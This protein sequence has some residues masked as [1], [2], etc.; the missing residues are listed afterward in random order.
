MLHDNASRPAR[1]AA[2][3]RS[4]V[5]SLAYPAAMACAGLASAAASAQSPPPPSAS[6]VTPRSL[7]PTPPPA[8]APVLE[9]PAGAAAKAPPGSE[10]LHVAVRRVVIDGGFDE[11]AKE[12]ARLAAPVEG[13]SVTVA[14]LYKVAGQIEAMYAKA[15]YFLVRAAVPQ[16]ALVDGGDFRLTVIDGFFDVID[17]TAVPRKLKRPVRAIM[18]GLRGRHKLKLASLQQRLDAAQAVPGSRL[19]ST[20]AQGETAGAARLILDGGFKPFAATLGGDNKLG[21]AF[22]D[23]GLNL[24]LTANS[25]TGH[26]EQVYA[27]L[28]GTPRR[29]LFGRQANRRILG[30]GVIA[31]LNGQGLT[32]NP[33]FTFS[34]TRPLTAVPLLASHDKLYRGALNIST[35]VPFGVEG[36]TVAKLTFEGVDERNAFTAFGIDV[37]HDK[38]AIV[39][40]N[41]SWNGA[42]SGIFLHADGTFS[43]GL[44]LFGAGDETQKTPFSRD[45]NPLFSKGEVTFIASA[46]LPAKASITATV[47]GQTSFGDVLPNAETFDPG[48]VDGL[49]SFT[50]GV[51]S[52]DSGVSARIQI[53]RPIGWQP[54][55]LGIAL[56]PYVYAAGGRM[57]YKLRDSFTPSSGA[58]YGVG[59]RGSL[60]GLPLGASPTFTLEYGHGTVNRGNAPTNRLQVALGLAF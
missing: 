21:P 52:T 14:D 23:W 12:S 22:N 7:R 42:L 2:R 36:S 38:L 9:I 11:F 13:K 34:D 47:R 39:R 17:D 31:P 49:S 40:A 48:S 26:G 32:I 56:T 45:G 53:D 44:K 18:S 15:G 4:V 54:A 58:A 43:K 33:E 59:I 28:S 8:P 1:A 30:G 10:N 16:Q 5:T 37:S 41:L 19:R 46:R 35:P 51:L 50:S 3:R 57:W 27:F 24:Q 55:R 20:I 6:Q 25:P 29:D 60:L